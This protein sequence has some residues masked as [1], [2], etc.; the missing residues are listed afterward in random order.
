VGNYA[1]KFTRLSKYCPMLV[2]EELVKVRRFFKGQQPELI[3]ALIGM[4]PSTYSAVVE[5]AS[6]MKERI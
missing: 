6:R 4:A 5:I 1:A 2:Q 3:R